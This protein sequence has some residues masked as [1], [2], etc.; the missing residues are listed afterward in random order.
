MAPEAI[1]P[2]T[3]SQCDLARARLHLSTVKIPAHSEGLPVTAERPPDPRTMVS[4]RFPMF[5]DLR[6]Y[7]WGAFQRVLHRFWVVKELLSGTKVFLFLC[8]GYRKTMKGDTEKSIVGQAGVGQPGEEVE[9]GDKTSASMLETLGEVLKRRTM[10]VEQEERGAVAE[11]LEE[12]A[13]EEDDEYQVEEEE[14]DWVEWESEDEDEDKD[15]LHQQTLPTGPCAGISFSLNS[16][17]ASDDEEEAESDNDDDDDDDD[18]EDSDWSDGTDDDS[19]ASAESVELWES[20]LHSS[21]PYNPLSFSSC[22]SPAKPSYNT[23]TSPAREERRPEDQEED[24]RVDKQHSTHEVQQ[25]KKVRFSDEVKVR[26][27]VA[28]AFASRAARDGSYWM[29]MVRD[30]DR[31]H[32]RVEEAGK[33][34]SPCL[35][36]KHRCL[37]WERLQ[38]HSAL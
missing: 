31:F 25:N 20:F 22:T 38:T 21:D 32:R 26:P 18:E 16:K 11:D 15:A 1:H 29:Q 37:V 5:G 35:S 12:S 14:S 34:I 33:V 3:L 2:H 19:E 28:W 23:H 17:Q 30:R 6:Q 7:L 36:H 13:D 10:E 9:R 24:R 4:L 27:L 8:S